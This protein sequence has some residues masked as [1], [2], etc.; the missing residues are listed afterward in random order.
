MSWTACKPVPSSMTFSAT[1]TGTLAT[2]P[3][4]AR[5]HPVGRSAVPRAS[6]SD[7]AGE[8]SDLVGTAFRLASA[9]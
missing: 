8:G 5:N 7:W 3:I 9:V 1:P 4:L 2:V 6:A